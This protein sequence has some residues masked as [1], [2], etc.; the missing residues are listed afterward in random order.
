MFHVQRSESPDRGLGITA[1]WPVHHISER[2]FRGCD[3]KVLRVPAD[4]VEDRL[5][6]LVGGEIARKRDEQCAR[7]VKPSLPVCLLG[8]GDTVSQPSRSFSFGTLNGVGLLT[9]S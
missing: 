8:G 7:L 2:V 4:R 1:T 5:D 6:L 3:P 9:L